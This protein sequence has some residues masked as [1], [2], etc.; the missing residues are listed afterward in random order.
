M[1]PW[2]KLQILQVEDEL[3][4]YK[5]LVE[6]WEDTSE[7]GDQLGRLM[8]LSALDLAERAI[9]VLEKKLKELQGENL[10]DQP[11]ISKAHQAAS[12]IQPVP[13]DAP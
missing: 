5:W 12:Q 7:D 6:N 4:Y 3:Q 8:N 1:S 2:K 9:P 10:H 13:E 11:E